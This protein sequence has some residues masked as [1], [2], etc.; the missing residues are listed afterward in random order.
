MS[1]YCLLYSST[2]ADLWQ[3]VDAIL[4]TA[5]RHNATVDVTG[6][7]VASPGRYVQ[8][9][10]G[11][12]AAVLALYERI[13]LDP[14]HHDVALVAAGPLDVVAGRAQRRF[15]EWS[16]SLRV[17]DDAPE[18]LQEFLHLTEEAAL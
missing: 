10:E 13:R 11:P 17:V 16:M 14:R 1:D 2:P 9:L 4:L 3:D 6:L 18:G 7:L 15:R 5:I 12:R 8:W